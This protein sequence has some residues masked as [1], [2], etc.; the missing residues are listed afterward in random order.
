M[1][2]VK[3]PYSSVT[4]IV[5]AF[6]QGAKFKV[7]TATGHEYPVSAIKPSPSYTGFRVAA[8]GKDYSMFNPDGTH[9]TNE[10]LKLVA[11]DAADRYAR[12]FVTE[13]E[14]QAMQAAKSSHAPAYRSPFAADPRP[15]TSKGV[16]EPRKPAPFL[17]RYFAG[18]TFHN[19][20][21]REI[22]HN[23]DVS[24]TQMVVTLRNPE[25]GALR[26]T[27]RYNLNGTHKFQADRNLVEG[28][29]P[30]APKKVR[31]KVYKN[32]INGHLFVIREGEV[33]P[34]IRGISNATVVGSTTITE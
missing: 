7:I 18:V 31:V 32:A 14:A 27:P 29:P 15:V 24:G 22:V 33:L 2:A 34:N 9:R 23:V 16:L 10:K 3:L 28:N 8:G 1:Q 26:T 19:P 17:Q 30:K 21:T 11:V 4:Q 13:E 25:T 6:N 20:K 12:V 5:A